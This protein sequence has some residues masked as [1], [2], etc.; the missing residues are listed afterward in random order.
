MITMHCIALQCLVAPVTFT[1]N[2]APLKPYLVLLSLPTT[3]LATWCNTGLVDNLQ[4]AQTEFKS[5][6]SKHWTKLSHILR[7]TS[8]PRSLKAWKQNCQS[9]TEGSHTVANSVA[10]QP[11]KLIIW[12]AIWLFTVERNLSAAHSVTIPVQEKVNLGD[13]C[14]ISILERSLSGAHNVVT[15]AKLLTR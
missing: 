14:F 7:L 2:D 13:M 8:L 5:W 9:R 1:F 10:S 11:P 3:L 4:F 15:L 12:M 6:K